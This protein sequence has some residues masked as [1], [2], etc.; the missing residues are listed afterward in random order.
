[1]QEAPLVPLF[2]G[3]QHFLVKP[4]VARFQPP[5]VT[6]CFARDIVIERH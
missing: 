3:R 4:W 2:Y 1:M 5:L 6:W